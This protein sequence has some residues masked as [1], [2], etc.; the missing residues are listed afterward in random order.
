MQKGEISTLEREVLV[1]FRTMARGPEAEAEHANC[2]SRVWEQLADLSSLSYVFIDSP[3]IFHFPIKEPVPSSTAVVLYETLEF[4]EVGVNPQGSPGPLRS[5]WTHR[6]S[7][8][9]KLSPWSSW[10]EM[11]A[12]VPLVLHGMN[13]KVD[14]SSPRFS[15]RLEIPSRIPALVPRHRA[16]GAVILAPVK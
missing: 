14:P 16:S 3:Q 12:L 10:V 5:L 4:Q 6:W 1:G 15:Q 13:Q 2:F 8:V 7:L 11:W 9:A